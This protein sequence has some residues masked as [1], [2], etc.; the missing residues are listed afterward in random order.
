MLLVSD[1]DGTIKKYYKDPT[2]F[3]KIDL[4]KEI[5]AINEFVNNGNIFTISTYRKTPSIKREIEKY[6]ILYNYL[7]VYN[8]LVTLDK[9]DRVINAKYIDNDVVKEII[10]IATKKGFIDKVTLYNE[11]GITDS[12][13]N[14]IMIG[15]KCFVTFDIINYIKNINTFYNYDRNSFWIH[16]QTDKVEAVNM[17]KD[18]LKIKEHEIY[19]IGDSEPDSEMVKRYN[20]HCI[21]KS[22]LDEFLYTTIPREKNVRS[23][24]KKIK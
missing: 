21:I 15:I 7:T 19:T 5:K 13:N 1:Y 9:K 2:I 8:G 16:E 14:I 11:Y 4:K 18:Y 3:E 23:L 20:G 10:T 12:I 17:L 6:K 22:D 24:I